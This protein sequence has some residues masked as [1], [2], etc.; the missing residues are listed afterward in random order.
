MRG[1]TL[2]WDRLLRDFVN[3]LDLGKEVMTNQQ[4][5]ADALGT[6]TNAISK[7][8]TMLRALGALEMRVGS[9]GT[10]KRTFYKLLA[11]LDEVQRRLKSR[12]WRLS[13]DAD[14]QKASGMVPNKEAHLFGKALKRRDAADSA[15]A[16]EPRP[17]FAVLAP[18]RK[19][20]PRA[21]I[22]MARKYQERLSFIEAKR[23]EFSEMGIQFNPDAIEFTLDP[24]LEHVGL[25]LP[26]VS[27]LEGTNERLQKEISTT[28]APSAELAAVRAERDRQK[29]QIAR[30]IR[31]KAEAADALNNERSR[32]RAE[33][34][35]KER[36]IEQLTIAVAEA[37]KGNGYV[38]TT[39]A[40]V[41]AA[42]KA[43]GA[44]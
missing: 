27:M 37:R 18:M 1:Q 25:V 9:D 35:R 31:E 32:L 2:N 4:A 43:T 21:L 7:M 34:L 39:G 5:M 40:K 24:M 15:P 8:T 42:V 22:E 14:Y 44:R 23:A 13:S 38:K 6:Q 16:S 11:D 29:E 20:E 3:V 19:D 10:N 26:Y 36:E 12:G 30:L 17:E 28:R 33:L 41:E